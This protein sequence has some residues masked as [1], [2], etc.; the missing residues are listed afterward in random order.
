MLGIVLVARLGQAHG[1]G[2]LFLAVLSAF[3]GSIVA[4]ALAPDFLSVLLLLVVVN[5]MGGMSDVLSQS[6]IQLSVPG[7][8]R[9][10]AGGAWVVAI[11]TAPL[12]QLQIGAVASWLGVT[13]ALTA[14]GL[15]LVAVAAAG[16]FLVPRL[17]AR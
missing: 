12:G 9:G 14:S 11:G 3:G 17:R 13:V 10:R 8:L 4:L 15:A 7:E 2:P 5:A 1:N 6:L 16:A